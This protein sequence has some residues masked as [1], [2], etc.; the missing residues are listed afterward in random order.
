MR[1]LKIPGLT[2][3]ISLNITSGVHQ[4]ELTLRG[5]VIATSPIKAKTI[6]GIRKALDAL[7]H[8][9]EISHQVQASILD[10]IARKLFDD[11][12]YLDE[13]AVAAGVMAG[14]GRVFDELSEK[15]DQILVLVKEI[16]RR[17]RKI[18]EKMP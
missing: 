8:T 5:A 4:L 6:N 18:E 15:V 7:V 1:K 16:D 11:S 9:G 17:L 2:H 13:T 14:G 10:N 3:E 12:G